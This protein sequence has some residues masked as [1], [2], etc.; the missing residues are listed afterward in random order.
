MRATGKP[1]RRNRREQ[2]PTSYIGPRG[3]LESRK[4][5][6]NL[7]WNGI[8]IMDDEI[9]REEENSEREW[10]DYPGENL[11]LRQDGF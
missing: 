10:L 4:H 2:G 8:A 3:I 9:R 6:R 7:E 11:R 1:V 5:D